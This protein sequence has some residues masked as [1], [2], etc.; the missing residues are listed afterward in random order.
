MMVLIRGSAVE[1]YCFST[2]KPWLHIQPGMFHFGTRDGT[3]EP[4]VASRS[5]L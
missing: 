3:E 4:G 1:K 5:R 2:A